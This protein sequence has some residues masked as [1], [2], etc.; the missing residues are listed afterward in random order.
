MSFRSCICLFLA[1]TGAALAQNT[2]ESSFEVASVKQSPPMDMQKLM[3]AAQA[4][5]RMPIGPSVDRAQAQYR[6]MSLTALIAL[7]YKVNPSQ[8]TGPDW[9]PSA[10]WDIVAKMPQGSSVDQA[11]AMLRTLL[12]E[13]FKLSL[14]RETK[15]HPVLALVVGKG[16]L[17]LQ[18]C[19]P[20][21]PFDSDAP[22]RPGEVEIT[23]SDGPTRMYSDKATGDTFMDRGVNG[24]FRIRMDQ[25]SMVMHLDATSVTMA[26]FAELLSQYA[27]VGNSGGRSVVNMTGLKGSYNLKFDFSVA[28]LIATLRT[29]MDAAGLNPGGAPAMPVASE[30]GGGA[31]LVEAVAALGLKLEPRKAPVEQLVIDHVEKMPTEN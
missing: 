25:A 31:S 22:F 7:A 1:I 6:S 5:G 4:G 21:K 23:E 9:L 3:A 12:E 14:H 30:P 27:R 24:K 19:E 8:I 20:A 17:K 15:D 29:Q 18:E 11:P 16:G 10:R 2:P 28:E 13:R 26:G